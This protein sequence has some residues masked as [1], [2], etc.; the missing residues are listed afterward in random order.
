MNATTNPSLSAFGKA[1]STIHESP[2]SADE[3]RLMDAY[4]RTTLYLC[5]GMIYLRENPLLLEPLKQEHTKKR[6]LGHWGSDPG[7]SANAG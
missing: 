5:V 3:L 6:L 4:W 1:R 2:L 7:L